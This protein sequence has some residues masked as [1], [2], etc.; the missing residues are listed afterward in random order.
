MHNFKSI[1]IATIVN[2]LNLFTERERERERKIEIE[3]GI[4]NREEERQR[5]RD[6][7]R[8]SNPQ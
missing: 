8:I 3:R 2:S 5:D 4:G 6:T 7:P 1:Y